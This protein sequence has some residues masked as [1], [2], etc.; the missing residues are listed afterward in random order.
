MYRGTAY[1]SRPLKETALYHGPSKTLDPGNQMSVSMATS[2]I[3]WLSD[4]YGFE[5]VTSFCFG[6]DSF[7]KCFGIS[8]ETAYENW[9]ARII[10]LCG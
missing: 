6:N 9:S 2:M 8:F 10:S 5:T 3:A 7:E 4:Q 1:E